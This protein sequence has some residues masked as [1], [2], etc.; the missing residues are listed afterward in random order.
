MKYAFRRKD[1][2]Y[3][4][5]TMILG[6]LNHFLY[7]FTEQNPFAA[8]IAPINESVW[9]HMKLLFFPFLLFSLIEYAIRRPNAACF[10]GARF[11]GIWIG[12]LAVIFLFYGYSGILGLDLPVLDILL[13]YVGVLAAYAASARFGKTF[14]HKDL[15]TIFLWWTATTLL[16]FLFTCFPPELPLFLSPAD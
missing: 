16:F 5:P 9:E 8:L 4:L 3:L 7:D 11:A 13:F 14:C 6:T 12:M 2:P 10:F 1:I 15:L